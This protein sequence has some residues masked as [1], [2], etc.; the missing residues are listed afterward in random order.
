MNRSL[1]RA[2]LALAIGALCVLGA[3]ACGK[4]SST[5]SSTARRLVDQ[6]FKATS[7]LES[8]G[9]DAHLE[10]A[11][12]GLLAIGGPITLHVKGP[13]ARTKP[14]RH[15]LLKLHGVA[16]VA[17]Q[18]YG[19][20]LVADGRRAFLELDGRAYRIGDKHSMKGLGSLGLH[21][22]GWLKDEQITGRAR[23]AGT[24]TI[25]VTGTVDPVRLADDLGG[26][27]PA[28]LRKQLA[29]AVKTAKFEL[30]TGADDKIL[31][32]L[33]LRVSFEF[34]KGAQPPI[35]GLQAGRIELRV[36]L[37]DVNTKPGSIRAPTRSLP[38]SEAPTDRG[39][40]GLIHCLGRRGGASA[41]VQCVAALSP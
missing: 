41:V 25:H 6:T 2:V 29:G 39:L 38:L 30:W 31:R 24:E 11:P 12:E 17:G 22:R 1:R 33:T 7:A 34:P 21:P 23:I 19:G 26:L 36:G 37:A 13:V 16:T 3:V 28:K 10:L 20:D 35:A 14:H 8:A 9:L 18:R 40:G 5:T 15:P 32:Q 27:V 4:D